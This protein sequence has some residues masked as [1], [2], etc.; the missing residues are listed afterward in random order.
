MN[1]ELRPSTLR[2]VPAL[3]GFEG[4]F[5]SNPGQA[6]TVGCLIAVAAVGGAEAQDKPL[7]P[8]NSL[9][10]HRSNRRSTAGSNLRANPFP[11]KRMQP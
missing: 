9:C 4:V 3:R 8:V 2:G 6:V 11:L 7:P 10:R 5:E 1:I